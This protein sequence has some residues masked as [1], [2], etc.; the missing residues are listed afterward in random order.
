MTTLYLVRHGETDNNKAACFNGSKTDQPLNGRGLAQA[1]SL[2]APFAEILPDV[3]FSSPLRRAV[4]TAEGLRGTLSVPIETVEGLRE[5]DMG[6]YDGVSFA[7]VRV[8]DPELMANWNRADVQMPGGECFSKVQE[9]VFHTIV[10]LV[11][12]NRGK[13]LAVVA[14]G[15]LLQLFFMRLWQVPWQEKSTLPIL[16]NAGYATLQIADDGHVTLLCYDEIGHLPPLLSDGGSLEP[17]RETPRPSLGHDLV[18][19]TLLFADFAQ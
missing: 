9:R 10:G 7:E 3:I 11:A 18:G 8:R 19:K 16:H 2:A 12:K 1:A 17:R 4:G 6:A 14:H 15:T 13:T 5:M